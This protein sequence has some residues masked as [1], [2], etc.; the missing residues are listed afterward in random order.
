MMGVDTPETGRGWRSIPR[1]S[2]ASSWF[3][4]TRRTNFSLIAP[5]VG[6]CSKVFPASM[7]PL[8]NGTGMKPCVS[9]HWVWVTAKPQ[10]KRYQHRGLEKL[11]KLILI[12]DR[13][14]SWS[15]TFLQRYIKMLSL[16][17]RK[18]WTGE[19]QGTP[20]LFSLEFAVMIYLLTAIGLSPGG[21]THLHTNNT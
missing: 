9:F 7:L 4:F 8:N 19:R 10:Q 11:W 18:L 5:T 15:V 3:F 6:H 2:C 1:R 17:G 12:C 16:R 13:D 14:D 20:S 21:S